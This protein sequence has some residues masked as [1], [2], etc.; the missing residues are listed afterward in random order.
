MQASFRTYAHSK[1][2]VA[3]FRRFVGVDSI[4]SSGTELVLNKSKHTGTIAEVC[5]SKL[6]QVFQR[7]ACPGGLAT[8]EDARFQ[9]FCEQVLTPM[10]RSEQKRVLIYAPSYLSFVRIRNELIRREVSSRS[11][12]ICW[13]LLIT[14]SVLFCVI[15]RW[16]QFVLASI[17]EKVKLAEDEVD[18]SMGIAIFACTLDA[19]ISLGMQMYFQI[20]VRAERLFIVCC[21]ISDDFAFVEL[22]IWCSIRFPN[23]RHFILK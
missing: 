19:H 18:F 8:A 20:C 17:Q 6:A 13:S 22:Q 12:V 5:C 23:K 7:V 1:A 21:F 4:K 9:Y 11:V 2:G 3:R 15:H 10:L 16:T 14:N